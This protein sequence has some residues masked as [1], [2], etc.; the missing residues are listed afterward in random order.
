MTIVIYGED[1]AKRLSQLRDEKGI[2]A[3]DFSLNL[4]QS[5]SYINR[6]EN[7]KM[8]PSLSMFFE[9]CNYLDIEPSDFLRTKDAPSKKMLDTIDKLNKLD[10]DTFEHVAAIID[11]LSK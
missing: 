3:R 6:I 9:I 11:D 1:F 2:S 10:D 4:G 7:N 8:L 5:E